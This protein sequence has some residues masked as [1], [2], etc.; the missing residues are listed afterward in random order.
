MSHFAK[1]FSRTRLLI[2]DKGQEQLQQ[3]F[4]LI[5]GLG[6]V[7]GHALEGIAR[8]GVGHIRI[9]DFDQ[10]DETNINRQLLATHATIGKS[11]TEI[12]FN[13]I[14]EIN[15][16]CKVDRQETFYE[17]G[18]EE[19]LFA[20]AFGKNRPSL[21][22][23]CIDSFA[24][25]VSLLASCLKREIPVLSSMGAARHTDA[26]AIKVADISKTSHCPLAKKVRLALREQGFSKG[27]TTLFST[28]EIQPSQLAKSPQPSQADQTS[29]QENWKQTRLPLGSLPTI[30]ALFGTHLAHLAIQKIISEET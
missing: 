23:D 21:V 17:Q 2:G 22:I 13:R 9:V 26:F 12:A 1:Q 24:S 11:K 16:N 30:T 14:L 29:T 15:P 4:V 20:P 3:S 10:F 27:V 19:L 8:A 28:E 5:V 6:A 18:K 7:G 25:K